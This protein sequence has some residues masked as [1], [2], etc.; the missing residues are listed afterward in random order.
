M[1]KKALIIAFLFLFGNYN[2]QLLTGTSMSPVAL[3]QNVLL[4][5]G[6]T[7]SNIL[8]NGSPAALGS[9][10]A[11]NTNLGINEGVVLTTGTVIDNGEGPQGPNN[12]AGAG[13]DNN[14]GGSAL[15]S[16]LI[17]GTQTYNASILEFDFIPYSDTVRFKYVFGSDEY[18]EFAP[19][20][21]SGFN[22]VFGFFISG[23]GI[24]GI[25][26]I[27]ILPNGGGVV[28]INNVNAITNSQYFNFNGDGN[29]AP[30]NNNP[31]YIQYDGF[32]DVLEAISQVQCGQ[33]YHLAIA[34]AD[35]GDGAWD[36]G[37][38]LEANS[39]SSLTPVDITYELSNVVY[40]DPNW[41]AEGCVT[42][43]VTLER[44][45]NLGSP[46]TIP[47][48]LSGSA[49]DVLDYTGVPTSITFNPGDA[50]VSFVITVL[51]DGITEGLENIII[52]FPLADPCGNITPVSIELFI[53]D[54]EEV[55]VEINNSEISCPGDN[56]ILTTTV[57]GGV[58]PY[59]YLWNDNSTQSS[60]GISPTSTGQYFVAVTDDCLNQTAYDTVLV[61]VP[62]YQ[63][64]SLSTIPDIVEICPNVSQF[65]EV[66]ATGG[67]GNYVYVWTDE[68]NQVISTL[69]SALVAPTASTYFVIHVSDE[70]G[71]YAIDTVYYEV[72]SPPLEISTSPT[73][74]LCPGDSTLISVEAFGGFGTHYFYWPHS[75][76]T[77]SQIWVTASS[78]SS[79]QVQVSDDCQT[80]SISA[81]I[82]VVVV[83]PD[84]N[85]TIISEPVV[86]NLPISFQNLTTNGYVYEWYFGD[87]GYSEDVHPSHVY[88]EPGIYEVTLISTDSK[89]CVDSITIPIQI[90]K[91]FYI[92]IPNAFMP[93]GDRFNEVFSGSFVGVK[94]ISI[95]IYN[96]WGQKVFSSIDP[97]FEW[98]GYY[99]GK[100]VQNGTYTWKLTYIPEDRNDRELF[101]GHVTVLE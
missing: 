97:N 99:K 18:P 100:K 3:V 47:I 65:I 50:L 23:P 43:T 91:E 58:S 4:G 13:M 96:R 15:L 32:T 49:T 9:F 42:A 72:T 16:G 55:T 90:F 25:Q 69:D 24:S 82:Q 81:G 56:I 66:T 88:S 60:I 34:V 19:P 39:L 64:I 40:S 98:N 26:N 41:M 70:C 79:Y 80:F 30:Y 61:T 62:E 71:T 46:L 52:D 53:Q 20:N 44:Q 14:V 73:V 74:Y 93:D 101:T 6:V 35:V 28:S 87:G 12:Q 37:I 78:T 68:G 59:T 84:A 67:T 54:I 51:L 48:N 85:F 77:L 22:D 83:K 45:S 27:A 5:P 38:F 7:V 92:Y 75:G 57:S 89:G 31:F 1:G 8:Y 86:E 63:P 33:T 36:S 11:S 95:E 2:A 29:T 21:N 10:E 17:G 76:D 94:E